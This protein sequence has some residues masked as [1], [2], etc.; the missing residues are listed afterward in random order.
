MIQHIFFYYLKT[1]NNIVD[2]LLNKLSIENAKFIEIGTEDYNESNTR[3]LYESSNSKGLI[4][5]DSFDIKKLSYE[6]D[7]WKGRIIAVKERVTSSNI[8]PILKDNNFLDNID[9]FSIDIDGV[10][11]WIIKEL[12]NKISKIFVAEFNPL[13]GPNLEITVPNIENFNRTNYHYSNLCFGASLK[14]IINL[15]KSKG[16]VFM[17]VNK[18]CI[19]AFFV[20]IDEIKKINLEKPDDKN[21]SSFTNSNYRESRSIDGNLTFLTDEN[22]INEICECEVI[23]LANQSNKKVKIKD[24]L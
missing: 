14:A 10:D 4:V 1:H 15:M 2:Y 6:I 5:D 20:N 19:N 23:N 21:L 22:K 17:G 7:L 12:P 8:I 24:L 11:Y 13:F 3:F 16:F 18:N 9:L